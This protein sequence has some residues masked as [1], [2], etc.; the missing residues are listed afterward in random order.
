MKRLT[1]ILFAALL[2]A[3]CSQAGKDK[4]K[5]GLAMR[6]FDDP[7]S[8]AIRRAI[9]TE[10]MDKADVAIIDSQNQQSAQ[11]LQV[12]SFFQ[13]K[14]ASLAVD[15]VDVK[16]LGPIIGKAKAQRTPVVF[17]DRMPADETMRSWD[18]LFFV[19]TRSAEAGAALAEILSAYW[20][21]N[22]EADRNKDSRVQYILLAQDPP[23]PDSGL[24]EAAWAKA[25]SVAGVKS[26]RLSEGDATGGGKPPKEASASL[27]AKFGDKIEAV[28]CADPASALGAIEAFK[29]A[30]YFKGKKYVP[31]VGASPGEPAAQ[32]ADALSSGSLLG[33]AAADAQG[34]GNAVFDLAYALARGRDPSRA[35]W[36]VSDAKYVWVPY[37]KIFGN[38]PSTQRK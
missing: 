9:E 17:F 27:I 36:R 2:L 31:I 22:P 10:A 12:D 6:T 7:A 1:F 37:R 35:G 28:V 26:E 21:A 4:P 19:G 32:M 11:D 15:P 29:A 3:S 18:K 38:P 34:Q 5:L 13:R 16:A 30:G 33:I 25:L 8:V 14:L 24:L 20:K 23:S